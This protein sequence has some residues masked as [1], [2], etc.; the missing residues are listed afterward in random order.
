MKIIFDEEGPEIEVK[1]VHIKDNE[2][3]AN[4]QNSLYYEIYKIMR[5]FFHPDNLKYANEKLAYISNVD[6]KDT[7][8][9]VSKE[10]AKKLEELYEEYKT[11]ETSKKLEKIVIER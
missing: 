7:V 1:T 2:L 4:I 10:L 11:I 6:E 9:I 3:G 5:D 8:K